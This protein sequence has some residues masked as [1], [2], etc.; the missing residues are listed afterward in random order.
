M[1]E[2]QTTSSGAHDHGSDNP[3]RVWFWFGQWDRVKLGDEVRE[4]MKT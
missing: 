3:K 4:C 2:A 1:L